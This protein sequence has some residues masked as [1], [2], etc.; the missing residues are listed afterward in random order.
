MNH[1]WLFAR[2]SCILISMAPKSCEQEETEG[3]L[4]LFN[5]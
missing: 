5:V 4:A 1:E 2:F 3:L